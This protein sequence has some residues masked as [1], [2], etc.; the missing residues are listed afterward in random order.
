MRYLATLILI[1][2]GCSAPPEQKAPGEFEFAQTYLAQPAPASRE[3]PHEMPPLPS[4][5]AADPLNGL[6]EIP[7]ALRPV[8]K[9]PD[10]ALRRPLTADE[11]VQSH[12]AVLGHSGIA[13]ERRA[14]DVDRNGSFLGQNDD[15]A[16]R[17]PRTHDCI[18]FERIHYATDGHGKSKFAGRR[19]G[20]RDDASGWYR[21]GCRRIAEV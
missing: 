16:Q 14:A 20:G 9:S 3:S 6:V 17:A 13:L 15:L 5:P 7:D 10:Q 21:P 4:R 1:A 18:K 2:A 19:S 12:R 11:L 8:A